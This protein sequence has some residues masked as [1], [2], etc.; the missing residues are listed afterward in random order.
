ML[1]AAAEIVQLKSGVR[2]EVE[3]YA[4]EGTAVF[5]RVRGETLIFDKSDLAAP[6][7]VPSAP[8]PVAAPQAMAAAAPIDHLLDDAARRH[9]VPANLVRAVANVESRGLQQVTSRAGAIGVMQLMPETARAL[10][11]NPHD[12]AQNIDAGTR[13]L[14]DLLDRYQGTR[15]PLALALAAYNAGPGA[16]EHFGGVPPY[17]ETQRYVKKVKTWMRTNRATP[18]ASE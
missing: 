2:L 10:G 9:G 8:A 14:R 18:P 1:V 17:A 4:E 13:L 7:A 3:S 11:A 16:V 5:V 15:D 6:A 12:Q